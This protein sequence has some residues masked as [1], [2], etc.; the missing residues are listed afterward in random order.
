[1]ACQDDTFRNDASCIW[2]HEGAHS[3]EVWS[4]D[5]QMQDKRLDSQFRVCQENRTLWIASFT[6]KHTGLFPIDNRPIG[7]SDRG[8]SMAKVSLKFMDIVST[9][10]STPG[11]LA[12]DRVDCQPTRP[13]AKD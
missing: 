2:I 11:V 3:H 1:M 12:V 13:H 10:S 8:D 5:Y 9:F 6:Q 7:C 4:C